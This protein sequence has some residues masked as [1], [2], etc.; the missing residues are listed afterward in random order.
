MLRMLICLARHCLRL[1]QLL[2]LL[3]HLLTRHPPIPQLAIVVL[4]MKFEVFTR[5]GVADRPAP[6][7]LTRLRMAW[8][9][10]TDRR[11]RLRRHA[12]RLKW[13]AP[14]A[15][16]VPVKLLFDHWFKF[17]VAMHAERRRARHR[18]R[19]DKE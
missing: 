9:C 10:V 7:L 13:I 16:G 17:T 6:D 3:R 4:A 19:V 5:R 1:V 2:V 12:D 11:T 8:K 18:V 15:L 14:T